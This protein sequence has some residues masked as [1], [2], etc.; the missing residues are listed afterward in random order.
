M[1]NGK[2]NLK[3]FVSDGYSLT[4]REHARALIAYTEIS[5]EFACFLKTYI[6]IYLPA[7]SPGL[8]PERINVN[9]LVSH[10]LIPIDYTRAQERAF[11][12]LRETGVY[13]KSKPAAQMLA[14]WSHHYEEPKDVV[15]GL[16][17]LAIIGPTL[18]IVNKKKRVDVMQVLF[19]K[20]QQE[21]RSVSKYINI[22]NQVSM[23][24]LSKSLRFADGNV[25]RLEPELQHWFV[26]DRTL[27]MG[28]IGKEGLSKV[29]DTVKIN[30]VPHSI[31][32]EDRLPVAVA[33]SPSVRFDIYRDL[34]AELFD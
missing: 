33:I 1:N 24:L 11:W 29:L 4:L 3:N 9:D 25:S 30:N 12:V 20:S 16:I 17:G 31:Y 8:H 5:R 13:E 14:T 34:N 18:G 28:M 7:T 15:I 22:T 23:D 32:K 27:K 10:P 2:I 6:D 21:K 19:S 26:S